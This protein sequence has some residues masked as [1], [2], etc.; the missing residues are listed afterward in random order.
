MVIDAELVEDGGV[1]VAD[2]DRVF[3][4]V[5]AKVIGLTVNLAAFDTAASHPD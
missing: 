2:V 5:V 1:E 3:G 4:D